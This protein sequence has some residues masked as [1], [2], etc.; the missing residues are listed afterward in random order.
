MHVHIRTVQHV[1]DIGILRVGP[2][3]GSPA[4]GA[5]QTHMLTRG[6]EAAAL[7]SFRVSRGHAGAPEERDERWRQRKAHAAHA[8]QQRV[9]PP[10]S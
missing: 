8:H 3:M 9:R 4:P 2:L 7:F 5:L 10:A 1:C 6:K